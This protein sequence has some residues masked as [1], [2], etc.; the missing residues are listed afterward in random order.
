MYPDLDELIS[1]EEWKQLHSDQKVAQL[2]S[3][4]IRMAL[5]TA[6]CD[7]RKLIKGNL[8]ERSFMPEPKPTRRARTPSATAEY[9]CHWLSGVMVGGESIMFDQ[10][11]IDDIV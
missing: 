3:A 11:D 4:A 7:A 9:S 2:G 8:G 1:L 10:T 6:L 5:S